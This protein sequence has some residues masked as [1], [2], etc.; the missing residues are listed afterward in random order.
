MLRAAR[1][2]LRVLRCADASLPDPGLDASDFTLVRDQL[3]PGYG[4]PTEA[5]R[6]AIE[7]SAAAGLRLDSTYT[8]KCLAAI[9]ARAAAGTLEN[10]PVLFWNTYNSVDPRPGAPRPLDLELLP[11]AFRR[12]LEAP[13]STL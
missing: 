13:D 10:G 3:G 7:A 1:A 4:A 11:R 5:G 9:M 6:A 12:L 2:T 8:G